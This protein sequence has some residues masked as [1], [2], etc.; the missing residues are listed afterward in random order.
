MTITIHSRHVIFT[1]GVLNYTNLR[2]NSTA[3]LKS[4]LYTEINR[5]CLKTAG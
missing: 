3:L 2:M 4:V 1:L 5:V